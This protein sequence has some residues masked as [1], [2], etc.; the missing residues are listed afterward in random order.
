LQVISLGRHVIDSRAPPLL[1]MEVMPNLLAR[2]N[3]KPPMTRRMVE[4]GYREAPHPSEPMA[5]AFIKVR[6]ACR[7][8]NCPGDCSS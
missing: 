1:L 4:P 3:F 7:R 5:I 8:G 6:W 2:R